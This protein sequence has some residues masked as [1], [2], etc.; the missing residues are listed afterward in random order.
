MS[1]STR[2]IKNT[3]FLYAKMA[4]TV[5]ISLYSTRLI[6]NAL[7][8]SDYGIFNVVGGAIAMLGFLNAS[9][10]VATQRFMSYSE[11]EGDIEHIKQIFNNS[12]ILHVIIALIVG[13]ILIS[14]K[15]ILFDYLLN[16]ESAK[17]DAAKW[18]Y[19]F[20]IVSTIF[21]IVTVPY[22]A[23][24]NAHENM[25]Y[26][27]IIGIIQS[28]LNLGCAII[29]TRVTNDKLIWYGGLMAL[30]SMFV[31]L[32]MIVYCKRKYN[33]C[34]F[35][36]IRYYDKSTMKEITSFAGW[37]FIGGAASIISG[38]GIGLV[39]N[40]FYG[41]IANAAQGIAN[42]ISGQLGALGSNI[43]KAFNPVITK[44]EGAGERETIKKSFP[45]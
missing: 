12:L 33:E 41:T 10:A 37:N 20:M 30:I 21:T 15:P 35:K 38:Y 32:I 19:Y 39:L 9:M 5:F 44:S 24:M 3:G 18:I 13:I 4:I 43:K 25:L 42:Q 2:I 7:G 40:V 34:L 45:E 22:D 16:I 26:Y 14:L 23:T 27:S 31:L 29:I 28:L 36:P 1:T 6:L 8:A 11:G 17:I